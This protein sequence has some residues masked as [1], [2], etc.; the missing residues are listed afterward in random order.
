MP[1]L[2]P[3]TVSISVLSRMP[4]EVIDQ[5]DTVFSPCSYF[6]LPEHAR[7]SLVRRH[8]TYLV[9]PPGHQLMSHASVGLHQLSGQTLIVPYADELFGPYAQNWQLAVRSCARK[10]NHIPAPNVPTAL[11]LVSLGQGLLI[12]PRYIR[13][14]LS[15]ETFLVTVS[16]PACCFNESIY[17]AALRQNPAAEL[18]FDEFTSACTPLLQ[19][20]GD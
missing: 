13:S 17:S 5:Y 6:D 18:F 14:F 10:L 1:D 20:S 12:A 2:P 9:L 4:R 3:N 11:L 7:R 19:G 8:D 16:N 15:P